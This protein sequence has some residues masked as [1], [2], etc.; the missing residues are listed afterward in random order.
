MPPPG[1]EKRR[2]AICTRSEADAIA[3]EV[4]QLVRRSFITP[5]D[6]SDIKDLVNSLDDTI[7]QMRKTAKAVLLFEVEELEPEMAKMGERILQAAVLTV[8][9]VK[10]KVP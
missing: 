10:L 8:E 1:K 3:Q 6:R 5:F 9:A 2:N 4:L 7:D